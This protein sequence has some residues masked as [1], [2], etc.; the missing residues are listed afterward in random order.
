MRM[1]K[2]SVLLI[3]CGFIL[4]AAETGREEAKSR[5]LAELALRGWQINRVP[6]EIRT[7][8][9]P[10]VQRQIVDRYGDQ[11]EIEN[12]DISQL[13]WLGIKSIR[14]LG[15]L[16]GR[17]SDV[18]AVTFL[19]EIPSADSAFLEQYLAVEKRYYN[20]VRQ[21]LES[22]GAFTEPATPGLIQQTQTSGLNDPLI[23]EMWHLEATNVAKL[24]NGGIRGSNNPNGSKVIIMDT[25]ATLHEDL[26]ANINQLESKSFYG[27]A[28][29]RDEVG[30]GIS[31]AGTACAVGDNGIG[32]TGTSP[33][34]NLVIVKVGTT[35][36]TPSRLPYGD[37]NSNAV[38]EALYHLNNNVQ[39]VLIVNM[40][41]VITGGSKLIEEEMAAGKDRIV[42]VAAVGNNGRSDYVGF[43]AQLARKLKNVIA[44][45]AYDP[46]GAIS[47]FSNRDQET[48][49]VFAPGS[50]I[51]SLVRLRDY[52]NR[53]GTSFAAP[54]VT[55]VVNL[56][57]S[58]LM[59]KDV[60][61]NDEIIAKITLSV[62]KTNLGHLEGFPK[63]DALAT[64]KFLEPLMIPAPQPNRLP[65]VELTCDATEVISGRSINCLAQ[66]SDPDGDRLTY[67]WLPDG[68]F[69]FYDEPGR[70]IVNTDGL[71][72]TP[73]NLP[74][75]ID[76]GVYVSD[77]RG[78][79]VSATRLITIV[80]PTVSG[81]LPHLP[82][83]S[84]SRR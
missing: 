68:R 37:I 1:V 78:G 48:P 39:G 8:L 43:P 6:G 64:Y 27:G 74:I 36:Y 72:S 26:V 58:E 63:L 15:Q 14:R 67:R 50:K 2:L 19:P 9:P 4:A 16:G 35:G 29:F 33:K 47:S 49:M 61:I 25:G 84:R 18:Y 20:S 79:E 5:F 21:S 31:V 71:N 77:G 30:H 38:L 46:N 28:V 13:R 45:G 51:K 56:L 59:A 41:F 80:A 69:T 32:I 12:P 23:P 40:S 22:I 57:V 75:K 70:V 62:Q 17:G 60:S 53:N 82:H 44:V 42:F 11:N 10:A 55:G 3:F 66:A 24:L 34:C 54:V 76:I 52:E 73:G 7:K 81:H 65:A 83:R